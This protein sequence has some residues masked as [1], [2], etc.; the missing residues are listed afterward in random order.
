M[1]EIINFTSVAGM[2]AL[3]ISGA[4]T[5]MEKRFDP[6]GIFIIGFVTGAGGGTIR[7]MTLS[8]R[9][10]FWLVEP[11]YT[12]VAIAGSIFA[13]VF[14]KH[15]GYLRTTLSLFDTIG[16][17]LYTVIGVQIGIMHNLPGLSCVVYI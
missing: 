4:L 15:L 8:G 3:A 2:F 9:D 12:Y 14:R 1:E 11:A 16:L 17:A 5:A 7:D 6:F 13:I 10:V